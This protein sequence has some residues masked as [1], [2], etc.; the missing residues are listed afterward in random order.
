MT[1]FP[2]DVRAHPAGGLLIVPRGEIAPYA[3]RVSDPLVH[4][5]GAAPGRTL[6]ARRDAS[7]AWLGVSYAE[8]LQRVRALGAGLL[9]LGL[10]AERPIAI[11]SGN[12][13]EHLLLALA[14][15]YVGIPYAPVSP[16]YSL[17]R[18]DLA[19][20]RHVVGLLTP[21]LV[22][23]FGEGPFE[24]AL[25]EVVPAG[26]VVLTDRSRAT[27]GRHLDLDALA[28]SGDP[29]RAE[30]ERQAVG[31]D[32]IAKF[33]LTSGSTGSPKAVVTTHRMMGANQ[34]MIHQAMPFL[35]ERPPVLV[36]WLPWNH[37]FGGSH[38]VG[39][40]LT[41]GGTLHIDDGRP[42]PAGI[43]E[44][45]RNLKEVS[46]TVYFNVPKGFEAL[47]PH[48][49]QDEALRT[50]FYRHLYAC[51]FAGA[52][53]AQPVWDGLDAVAMQATGRHVPMISGL[54]AT[55]TGP[56]VTFTTTEMGRAGLIGLPVA[57]NVVKLVPVEGKLEV[58]ARGPNVT[59]GYWR[60]PAL[61]A[62]AFDEEG[63][64][65]LGDAVRFLDERDPARGL[66][67][68]GRIA[69]DFKL[70]SGTWV[71]VGPLRAA[72]LAALSPLLQDVVIAGLDRDDVGV[73]LF[74]D[75]V[76]CRS[77]G[78][79][80]AASRSPGELAADPAIRREIAARLAR[81][82]R[83]HPASSK[84][85]VRAR[86]MSTPP[87]LELGEITDKGSFNQRTVLRVR[88]AEVEALYDAAAPGAAATLLVDSPPAARS[89]P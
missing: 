63:Y 9:G 6:V 71:S 53:L 22:A 35:S 33:L 16:A 72:L 88:A 42:T 60:Q 1:S 17:A 38:N 55:E 49:Q 5:A 2:V 79:A 40:V 78:G 34:A 27:A 24:R 29:A 77:I 75:P 62:A 65:R 47:L 84:H 8:A 20:L 39:I 87:S 36:D 69:E 7:G 82:A 68:D 44:T 30:A 81:F 57:G 3:T 21:G 67:F 41:H 85:P 25:A 48:L 58:R 15:M 64:Y 31:G 76:G 80:A 43:L 23:V 83:E 86:L 70:S 52:G 11:L 18:G 45:V 14:A 4:W 89:A 73:L 13:V 50:S 61:T 56:S 66:I 59:P 28:A 51:F 10:S 46:P 12:S 37:V 32:T 26:T 19:T 74:L 54:G